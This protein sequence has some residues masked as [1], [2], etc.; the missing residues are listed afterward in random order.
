MKRWP[1]DWH[2]ASYLDAE[3]NNGTGSLAEKEK[4]G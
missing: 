3:S 2:A 1:I 4:E